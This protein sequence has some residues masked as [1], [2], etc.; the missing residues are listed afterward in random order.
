MK[1]KPVFHRT[2][3]LIALG[4]SAGLLVSQPGLANSMTDKPALE[5]KRYNPDEDEPAKK[6]KS[7]KTLSSSLNNEVVKIYPDIVRR[8]MH[9]V[10]KDNQGKGIDFFVFDLQGTIVQH[11]KLKE[12]D[13]IKITG[14][15][16][17]K[18]IYRVFEGDEESASG[19]FEIR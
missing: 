13:H 15:A 9:V 4:M 19:H 17:G 18:Y 2:R 1:P 6:S 14:L 16:R 11:F 12:K 10:A 7:N 8:Q 5:R 3:A